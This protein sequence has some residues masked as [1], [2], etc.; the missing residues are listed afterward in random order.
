MVAMTASHFSPRVM[1]L[2][3][4][5]APAVP[6]GASFV[7]DAD[8]RTFEPLIATSMQ[9]PLVVEFWSPRAN[10]AAFSADLQALAQEAAG[11]YL[12]VRVNVDEARA[13]AAALQIQAV[14]MV[15]G[16]VGG[17]LAPLFQGTAERAQIKAALDELLKVAVANGI[18]G[19]AQPVAAA[20]AAG[21]ETGPDPR[22]EAADAALEAGDFARAEAEFDKLLA[23]NPGD[24]EASAGRA[25]ARLLVRMQ[26]RDADALLARAQAD[27]DDVEAH[28]A[29]ADLEVGAGNVDG[30][31]GRLIE[32][33]RRTAGADRDA[34]RV[35]LLEL[36][37]A[38]GAAEPVVLTAR[39]NLMSA[40][41]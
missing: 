16:I 37:E 29:V 36:F 4:L 13:I 24:A 30:A 19:R 31:F 35:R 27:P 38:V 7:T 2:S 20:S 3:A 32:L 14:P 5:K 17:Q 8:D 26:T 12:L 9:H 15:I 40:L 33:V 6:A 41:F 34:V 1:D 18:V 23:A 39:R 10:A 25:Q 11:R 22:F 28:L 21:E